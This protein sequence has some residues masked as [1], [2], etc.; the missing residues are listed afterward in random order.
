MPFCF[1]TSLKGD[2]ISRDVSKNILPVLPVSFFEKRYILGGSSTIHGIAVVHTWTEQVF[3][4]KSS[5]FIGQLAEYCSRGLRAYA[6]KYQL[7]L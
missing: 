1:G 4:A 5:D 6:V 2:V 7:G 3:D